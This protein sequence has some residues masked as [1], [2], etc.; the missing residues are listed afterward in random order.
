MN[1]RAID[2]TTTALTQASAAS[3]A[4]GKKPSPAGP[5][6]KPAPAAAL[7][8]P[9]ATV[10]VSGIPATVKPEDRALYM[11]ILKSVG[12]NVNAALAGLAAA[13]AK[14]ASS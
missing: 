14:E 4:P 8:T 13:E 10:A 11:Q 1:V 3:S 9:A 12:G 7:P 6:A 5:S 2:P